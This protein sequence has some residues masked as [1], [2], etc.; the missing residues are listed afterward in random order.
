M[1]LQLPD[2]AE[3]LK[4]EPTK[5]KLGQVLK[6]KRGCGEYFEV[7]SDIVSLENPILSINFAQ[8]LQESVVDEQG[9]PAPDSPRIG[10]IEGQTYVH[11]GVCGTTGGYEDDDDP[12]DK[13]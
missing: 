9:N 3:C 10:I 11:M 7:G 1:N 8:H 2:E 13:T 4:D 5:I 12:P 6:F